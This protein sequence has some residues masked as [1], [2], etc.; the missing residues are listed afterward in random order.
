MSARDDYPY[1]ASLPNVAGYGEGTKAL[2]EIDRLRAEAD[3]LQ[4][5]Y[6]SALDRLAWCDQS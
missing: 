6:D 1:L 3:R 4:T 5:L 2:D